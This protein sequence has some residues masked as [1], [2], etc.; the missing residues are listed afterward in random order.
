MGQTGRP[1]VEYTYTGQTTILQVMLWLFCFIRFWVSISKRNKKYSCYAFVLYPP[2]SSSSSVPS[3]FVGSIQQILVQ[4]CSHHCTKQSTNPMLNVPMFECCSMK[5]DMLLYLLAL[6][7]LT[8]CNDNCTRAIII[9][10]VD[11]FLLLKMNTTR[12]YAAAIA[13]HV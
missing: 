2:P 3:S 8:I 12:Q 4:W 7:L 1:L 6:L 13:T 9:I 5:H 11:W 10:N